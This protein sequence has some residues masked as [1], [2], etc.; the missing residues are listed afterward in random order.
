M[1]AIPSAQMFGPHLRQVEAYR[2]DARRR[3]VTR[4]SGRRNRL[5]LA[6][7][8]DCYRTLVPNGCLKKPTESAGIFTSNPCRQVWGVEDLRFHCPAPCGATQAPTPVGSRRPS[9]FTSPTT[10]S[11][12]PQA[13][14][15]QF[16]SFL[17]VSHYC[18]A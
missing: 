3:G 13:S 18:A 4:L 15:E 11:M 10:C 7:W 6:R 17:I 9:V 2:A 14:L 5:S 8:L 1:C 12:M 16:S